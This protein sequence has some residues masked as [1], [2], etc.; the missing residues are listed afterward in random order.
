MVLEPTSKCA[1]CG[2]TRFTPGLCQECQ[3]DPEHLEHYIRE[4]QTQVKLYQMYVAEMKKK[5]WKARLRNFFKTDDAP[6]VWNCCDEL[7]RPSE[8][9]QHVKDHHMGRPKQ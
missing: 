1:G 6:K 9:V 7:V 5:S 2:K 8:L 4:L 3:N